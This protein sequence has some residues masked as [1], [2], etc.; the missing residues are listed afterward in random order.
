MKEKK[1][2]KGKDD[3]YSHLPPTCCTDPPAQ[4]RYKNLN[5]KLQEKHVSEGIFTVIIMGDNK[6]FQSLSFL[7]QETETN[8][9]E[10]VVYQTELLRTAHGAVQ[11]SA[12]FEING[13]AVLAV[14]DR[15]Q[16][17]E[18]Y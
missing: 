1:N 3:T 14:F 5:I 4:F 11:R 16:N 8:S 2:I 18:Q 17:H 9:T 7:M 12:L 15:L 13:H 10:A 6:E